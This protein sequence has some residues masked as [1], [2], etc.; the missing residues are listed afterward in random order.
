MT[1]YVNTSRHRQG[2]DIDVRPLLY[3]PE[4]ENHYLWY[5]QQTDRQAGFL[6]IWK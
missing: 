3:L 5:M 2:P 6:K 4:P 1:V